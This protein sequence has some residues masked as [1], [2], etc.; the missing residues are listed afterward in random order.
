MREIEARI[1]N[2]LGDST[3]KKKHYELLST[4][5]NRRESPEKYR[6]KIRAIMGS[7]FGLQQ[8]RAS[9]RKDL[10]ATSSSVSGYGSAAS[11]KT[12]K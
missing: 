3:I 10:N 4:S 1:K 2:D 12:F 8:T 7:S 6:G 11:E 5:L 9:H